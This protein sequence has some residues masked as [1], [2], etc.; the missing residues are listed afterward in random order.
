MYV[1]QVPTKISHPTAIPT[2]MQYCMVRLCDAAAMAISCSQSSAMVTFVCN[3]DTLLY[4][5]I[6]YFDG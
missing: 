3:A 5:I 2:G 1:G 6:D 4:Q